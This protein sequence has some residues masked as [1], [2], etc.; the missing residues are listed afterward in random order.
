MGG[1]ESMGNIVRFLCA[2]SAL[3]VSFIGQYFILF[4]DS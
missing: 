2:Q 3:F 4:K 1:F